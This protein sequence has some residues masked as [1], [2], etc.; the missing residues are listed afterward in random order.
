MKALADIQKVPP[1]FVSL[2]LTTLST[3]TAP[4]F[5]STQAIFAADGSKATVLLMSMMSGDT[6]AAKLYAAVNVPEE[7][8]SGKRT[9]R[10][11]FN[12]SNNVRAFSVVCVMSAFIDGNGTCT[13]IIHAAANSSIDKETLTARLSVDQPAE[14]A[15]IAPLFVIAAG[16]ESIYA[17]ADGRFT[18]R[19]E[20][21]APVNAAPLMRALEINYR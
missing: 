5:A 2:L 11:E 21:A 6:D 14:L 10:L 20:Y 16:S 1:L 12:N 17:T 13:V 4:A 15:T 7:I 19:A 3:L 8:I 18:V 9:K